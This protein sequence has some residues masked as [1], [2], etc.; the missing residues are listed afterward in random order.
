MD[1]LVGSD[2][3]TPYVVVVPAGEGTALRA[4]TGGR[5]GA[6]AI[7][8]PDEASEHLSD[9]VR[10][11][12]EGRRYVSPRLAVD[13]LSSLFSGPPEP[14]STGN[15]N[16]DSLTK[17]EREVFHQLIDG[18]TNKEIA[19]DLGL[20]PKTVETYRGRIR[21]KIGTCDP[22]ELS[23]HAVRSGLIDVY[24]W[25]ADSACLST[26]PRRAGGRTPDAAER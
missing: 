7:V 13:A 5:S 15:S 17:R 18:R 6:F 16:F 19:F 22:I 12:L 9:A 23:R 20:S 21:E 8:S 4:I 10:A 1:D 2:G 3:R 26:P 11:V 24:E 25:A 14:T